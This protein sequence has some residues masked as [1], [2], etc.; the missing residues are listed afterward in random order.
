MNN[1]A[2]WA[3]GP[4]LAFDLETTG[5]DVEHDR[6]VTATVVAIEPGRAPEVRTWLADPGVDIP[7]EASEVH[8]ISTE[9]ARAHGQPAA[10]VVA[11][12]VDLLARTWNAETPLC[13]F[14]APFD[15]SLLRAELHRHHDGELRLGGPVVDP[16]CI[17]KQLDRYRKGKRTLS[18]LCEH[19]R[20][21]IDAAHDSAEDALAAARLAWR[22]A[23]TYSTQ[24]GTRPLDELHRDQAGWN[25]DQQL[26]FADYLDRQ[27]RRPGTTD[28]DAAALRARADGIRARAEHWPLLPL[29]AP[30]A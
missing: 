11:D 5:I 7:A 25:R 30:A 17:D 8:G 16:R 13:A 27:A 10:R 1:S 24:I 3:D 28:E 19:Y 26:D 23:K 9:H 4:L 12:V 14:N 2:C 29:T 15:L 20:V 21:R 18:A 22:L 6:I